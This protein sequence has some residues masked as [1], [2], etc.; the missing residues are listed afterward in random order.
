MTDCCEVEHYVLTI[1]NRIIIIITFA[2]IDFQKSKFKPV[3][4]AAELCSFQI[5]ER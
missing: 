3:F 2:A 4:Y 1:I 5:A